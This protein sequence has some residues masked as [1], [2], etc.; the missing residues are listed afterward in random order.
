MVLTASVD[1]ETMDS[2]KRVAAVVPDVR[3]GA[4]DLGLCGSTHEEHDDAKSLIPVKGRLPADESHRAL[5]VTFW[6][7]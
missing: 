7:P 4:D 6:A 3:I 5:A 1:P 2:G